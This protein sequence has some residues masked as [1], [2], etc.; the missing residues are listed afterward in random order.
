VSE[1]RHGF[2]LP[3]PLHHGLFFAAAG[4]FIGTMAAWAVHAASQ[5]DNFPAAVTFTTTFPIMVLNPLMLV[6][7][8]AF[9]VAPAFLAGFAASFAAPRLS[10]PWQLYLVAIGV[11]VAATGGLIWIITMP[12][13][14]PVPLAAAAVAAS[15]AAT[16]L[17][18]GRRRRVPLLTGREREAA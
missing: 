9:G 4:P 14:A 11:G 8:Y 15:A 10:A 16:R 6:F 1:A 17:A 7:G 3:P 13:E 18:R 5:V 12:P 2:R